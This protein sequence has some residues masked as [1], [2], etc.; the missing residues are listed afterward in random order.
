MAPVRGPFRVG[1][2]IAKVPILELL[3]QADGPSEPK[4][5]CA[6]LQAL[7]PSA[8]SG[9]MV[10]PDGKVTIDDLISDGEAEKPSNMGVL[11][12]MFRPEGA[13]VSLVVALA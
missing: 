2:P 7:W 8:A 10:K 3:G 4:L 1:E 5:A 9:L 12:S 13:S 11:S 6:S